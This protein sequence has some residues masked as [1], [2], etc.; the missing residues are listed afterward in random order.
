MRKIEFAKLLGFGNV[1]EGLQVVDFQNETLGDKL[2]AKVGSEVL[3]NKL[4][5]KVGSEV[6]SPAKGINFQD[7]TFGSRLGAK[8]GDLKSG[9]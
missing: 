2:G 9:T 7:E 6:T 3:G 8:V 5:A 4:G 1:S